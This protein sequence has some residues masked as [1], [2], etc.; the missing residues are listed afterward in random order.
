MQIHFQ[1]PEGSIE[2]FKKP[3]YFWKFLFG[4]LEEEEFVPRV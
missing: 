3:V 4:V 2:K 1:E